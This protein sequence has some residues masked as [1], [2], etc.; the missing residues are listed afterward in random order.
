MYKF[1]RVQNPDPLCSWSL[2]ML[3]CARSWSHDQHPGGTTYGGSAS[4]GGSAYRKWGSAYRGVCLWGVCIQGGVCLRGGSACKEGS[5]YRGVCL[6]GGVFLH[7]ESASRKESAYRG[8]AR[9]PPWTRKA[10]G[11]HPT[12]MLSFVAKKLLVRALKSNSL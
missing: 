6:W 2:A 7:G 9:P 4:R 5:A 11:T 3:E 10:G 1:I 8:L 12:G